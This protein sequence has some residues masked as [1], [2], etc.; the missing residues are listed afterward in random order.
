MVSE[1][2]Q[3]YF[4]KNPPA[5]GNRYYLIIE[6][7]QYRNAFCK[8][9]EEQS[10]EIIISDIYGV[11]SEVVTEEPYIT[12]AI[13]LTGDL[14]DIIV[15]Y[16]TTATEDYL[17]T[18]RNTVGVPG[19]KYENYCLMY[20]LADSVLSSIIT[21][22][23][24]LQAPGAPLSTGYIIESIKKKAKDYLIKDCERVYLEEHLEKL[25]SYI[26]DGTC[27]LFD[28][29]HALSILEERHLKG[30][31]NKLE[32][33]NDNIIYDPLYTPSDDEIKER[34]AYNH[35]CYRKVCDIMNSEDATDKVALLQKFLDEK[36]SKKICNLGE[37]WTSIDYQDIISSIETKAA[38]DNLT[39]LDI[40]LEEEGLMSSLVWNY[41][42]KPKKKTSNYLIICDRSDADTQTIKIRF[43]KPIPKNKWEKYCAV[44]GAN[45]RISV[46]SPKLIKESFGL[47]DNH[48][49]VMILRL[50]CEYSFFENIKDIFSINAKGEIVI[51]VPDDWSTLK[52]G[53]GATRL[54]RGLDGNVKWENNSC[55]EIDVS[56]EEEE[57]IKFSIF[58]GEVELKIILKVKGAAPIPPIGPS[59]IKRSI[60]YR[61]VEGRGNPFEKI[62]D[63]TIEYP[64]YKDWRFYLENEKFFIENECGS[65]CRFS[66]D[67]SDEH[68][69]KAVKLSLP[70]SVEKAITRI[71]D[72]YRS[73]ESVPSLV[74]LN[75]SLSALYSDY[76]SAIIDVVD[77]I[78]PEDSLKREEYNLCKLGVVEDAKTGNIYFSPFHPIIVAYALEYARQSHASDETSFADKLLTPFYLVPYL[79]YN[80]VN[81]RPVH[82]IK[83]DGLRNW[84]CYERSSDVPQSRTNDITTRMVCERMNDFIKHYDYLFQDK[85]CPII[86][87]CI[88]IKDD[89]N[90]IKGI[91]EFIKKSYSDSVQRIELHEYV[92][93]VL[94]E[95]FYEKLNRLD[96]HDAIIRAL[97]DINLK[98]ESKDKYTAQEIIHQLF[99]RVSFYKHSLK[100]DRVVDYSHIA[101]YLMNVGDN[102]VTKH[103]PS[104]RSEMSLY[105][106][107]STPSTT[108]INDNQYVLG[109]GNKNVCV[110]D[111]R[112]YR[113]AEAM[114]AL[115]ANERNNGENLFQKKAALYKLVSFSD[116]QLLNSI[117]KNSN[118]VTFINPEVDINFFYKQKLHI[119]H[120]TD[121]YTINAKYDS[122]TVTQ[123]IDQY[124]NILFA[125]YN[126][127]LL[128]SC[129]FDSF[130]EKM[131]KYFNCLNG[132]WLLSIAR[133]SDVQVR[134]KMSIVA[135]SI[136]MQ[137]FM[138]RVKNVIWLPLSL[139][140][141]LR[142]TGS[143]GLPQEHI[144]SKKSTGAKG[145]MSDDLLMMGFAPHN[146]GSHKLYLYP[147]EVK[148]SKT[149][150]IMA[151]GELQVCKTYQHFKQHLTGEANFTKDICCTFFASQFIT[152]AEKLH[153]HD[154][155]SD[156]EYA[157]IED[158]RYDLLNLRYEMLCQ[159]P[160]PEMGN[161]AVVSFLN[162][163]KETIYTSNIEGVSVCHLVFSEKECFSCIASPEDSS[164]DYLVDSEISMQITVDAN[165]DQQLETTPISL[166]SDKEK[167]TDSIKEIVPNEQIEEQNTVLSQNNTEQKNNTSEAEPIRVV[168]GAAGKHEVVF[169]PNNTKQV[170]HPNMAIIGTMGTGKTQLARSVIAQLS[171]ETVHNVGN[172]PLGLLVF[173]YKGD[174][175]DD[176][177]LRT[178]NGTTYKFNYPFNP[179]KLVL[180]DE[181]NGMNLPAITADR[182]SDSFAKAYGLGP[183]QQ[184]SIKNVILATYEEFGITRSPETWNKRPPTMDDVIRKYFETKDATD[185]AYALFDKLRDYSIF[186]DNSDNCVSLFEWLNQVR[187]IDLTPYPD[188]T[189]K[190][191]VSL[192]LDL[193]YAEMQQ[194]GASRFENGLRELRAMIIVDEAH[195]FLKK[196]FNSLRKIISE[197]RMFGVGMILSTQNIGDFKSSNE[198]YSSYIL[199]WAIHQVNKIKSSEMESIFGS[200]DPH[201]D[202]YIE[203]VNR[204]KMFHCVCKV[205]HEVY[206]LRDLPYFEL[207]EQ[208]AR[209]KTL[210]Q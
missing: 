90:V 88:G 196:D 39:L 84:I 165:C 91:I 129:L 135:A 208:D 71:F 2:L 176:D 26:D 108:N 102:Y 63:G 103:A 206:S 25:S 207:I 43:N 77:S 27:T 100:E 190:V 97:N 184:S 210:N 3:G 40:S 52:L 121:Q 152:I 194:L 147:I 126:K 47:N 16:D 10:E 66:N 133:K 115:Y 28:F 35:Q 197:G 49:D 188:D 131:M 19:S 169:E 72:Y 75:D 31:F 156:E 70:S 149:G 161:A 87:S 101:F 119:V 192:I 60:L 5:A 125:S 45:A 177:F 107:I 104:Y 120:Y 116:T 41:K 209:F 179:L 53:N 187:V 134:E 166:D 198:D 112:I 204:A 1:L 94:E 117:Y 175:K 138:Q 82:I 29:E 164:M 171:K 203:C 17:T 23:Q 37:N 6:Q 199:S 151:K 95:T 144:F 172:T 22:C 44:H 127:F 86:I 122:I 106:L 195:Q 4:K 150:Q 7:E 50:P 170:S 64:V 59:A 54:E 162:Q 140:E 205:G 55:L 56:G 148:Y 128:S 118:W 139:E 30:Y 200:A 159:L 89:A 61:E 57:K 81:M 154:L 33:F 13:R 99:T 93:N 65:I 73:I 141:I 137:R 182:L 62:T 163:P 34:V 136:L 58:F 15:G 74:P 110:N 178:V 36:L 78:L 98:I 181:V 48:H 160:I 153:A 20:V 146:N 11:H 180:T 18:L 68:I 201:V 183:V 46:S 9:I 92:E 67:F 24:D 38:T 202:K 114:N 76:L 79:T 80:D 111:G 96:S 14:P 193:F 42:G 69:T 168:L 124:K 173:D 130:N 174:Y 32:F 155:L 157:V 109:F 113:V 189:K 51:D 132:S 83:P 12:R 158:H 21:A 143:V 123:Q 145:P 185:K 85:D 167:Q 191:I 142:V 105:G 186:T 8:A